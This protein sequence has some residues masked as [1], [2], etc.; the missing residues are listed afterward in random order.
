MKRPELI[1]PV[2]TLMYAFS[3]SEFTCSLLV[4]FVVALLSYFYASDSVAGAPTGSCATAEI[5]HRGGC[6][7]RAV[8]GDQQWCV[9]SRCIGCACAGF[10]AAVSFVAIRHFLFCLIG[11]LR[12]IEYCRV[13]TRLFSW[14][15]CVVL[16]FTLSP[17]FFELL[18]P[19][20]QGTVNV[21][22]GSLVILLSILFLRV[23]RP[24][25]LCVAYALLGA[26][27]AAS[28][29]G[30]IMLIVVSM[31]LFLA[32]RSMTPCI[33]GYA[34]GHE[35]AYGGGYGSYGEPQGTYGSYGYGTAQYG[36]VDESDRMANA[37]MAE[38]IRLLLLL[39]FV[40]GFVFTLTLVFGYGMLSG[41]GVKDIVLQW[42][43]C[44]GAELKGML[45]AVELM[46]LA[47]CVTISFLFVNCRLARMFDI[48]YCL[49]LNDLFRLG[50]GFLLAC[51]I[52]ICIGRRVPFVVG[53]CLC[54]TPLLP[55]AIQVIASEAI[56]EVAAIFLVNLKCRKIHSVT[57]N[58]D[59]TK[60]VRQYKR[61]RAV[62]LLF[63]DLLP[64]FL[65]AMGIG[66]FWRVFQ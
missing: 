28:I 42:L 47:C 25:F 5:W 20:T 27:S 54:E 17:F 41:A 51:A 36:A 52:L 37:F 38:R 57:E 2:E 55:L 49:K 21:V 22:L 11:K 32:K 53:A 19:V 6:W 59:D 3:K 1:A 33:P 14:T 24:I 7:L 10:V 65:L 18:I 12:V 45:A 31:I 34:Y 60:A 48:E 43:S 39:C 15:M 56:L 30:V 29:T 23:K 8:L 50:A 44:F 9:Y 61:M 35:N 66:R 46:T 13:R 26:L 63:F 62:L 64:V 40:M 58:T 16:S 4:M